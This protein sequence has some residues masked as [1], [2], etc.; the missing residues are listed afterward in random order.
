MRGS[1]DVFQRLLNLKTHASL[2]L[3][4]TLPT[5]FR[6][7]LNFSTGYHSKAQHPDVGN[8]YRRNQIPHSWRKISKYASINYKSSWKTKPKNCSQIAIKLAVLD[9]GFGG[10]RDGITIA[11]FIFSIN[12]FCG[13]SDFYIYPFPGSKR[14]TGGTLRD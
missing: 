13:C 10:K 5:V 7:V 2:L 4:H 11:Y 9:F 8:Q 12:T 1:N 14:S 3:K 6:Y